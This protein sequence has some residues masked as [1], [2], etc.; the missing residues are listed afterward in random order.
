MKAG[1]IITLAIGALVGSTATYVLLKDKYDQM[2]KEDLESIRQYA[3]KR[4]SYSTESEN[5]EENVVVDRKSF[6]PV[7]GTD[8]Y[9]DYSA[10]SKKETSV[11]KEEIKRSEDIVQDEGDEPQ[12]ISPDECGLEEE[13]DL[14]SYT[15]YADGFL[16][17]ENNEIVQDIEGTVGHEALKSFG[18][19]EDDAVHIKNNRL[20]AYFEILRDYRKYSQVRRDMPHPLEDE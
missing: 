19:Y 12:I 13:Y 6:K 16:T 11:K 15:Y 20:E 14:I 18:E 2:R 4:D 10:I 5:I 9:V 3:N 7:V 8:N 17:D 1:Y